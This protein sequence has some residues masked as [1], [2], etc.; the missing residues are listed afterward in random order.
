[1]KT[2]VAGL[3]SVA[4]LAVFIQPCPAPF[5]LPG[6]VLTAEAN[7][8]V[9]AATVGLLAASA[10]V[11]VASGGLNDKRDGSPTH[12][13]SACMAD[14]IQW[15]PVYTVT[16]DSSIVVSQLPPSCIQATNLYNSHPQ[17]GM[18]NSMYGIATVTNE[19]TITITDMPPMM[20]AP[21]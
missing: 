21:G 15:K 12:V 4:A 3:Y 5:I 13:I 8:A 6:A 20:M 2:Y 19:S 7:A 1:M 14:M 10:S 16:G 17:I 11:I 18:M 9:A